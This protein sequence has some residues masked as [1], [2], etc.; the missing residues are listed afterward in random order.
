M[1]YVYQSIS[2][3]EA[4]PYS[5]L[6]S[7]VAQALIVLVPAA[8]A[9]LVAWLRS[10]TLRTFAK[11]SALEVEHRAGELAGLR[12]DAKL[13]MAVNLMHD[14]TNVLTR[15]TRVKAE[16]IVESVLPEVRRES[17]RPPRR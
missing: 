10:H 3:N 17:V 8:T 1:F 14:K 16:R 9:A 4:T 6:E 12:G 11:Q 7:I 15:V 2:P 5:Q 13:A